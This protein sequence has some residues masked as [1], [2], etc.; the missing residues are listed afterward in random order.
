MRMHEDPQKNISKAERLV[1]KA[2]DRGASIVCLPELF[3]T[4]YFAQYEDDKKAAKLAQRAPG[5]LCDELGG[6]AI[7]ED[8][9][10]VGGSLYEKEGKKLFNTAPVF[11]KDGRMVGKYRKMHI[12]HDFSYYEQNYF[13]PGDLGF[14]VVD[15]SAGR[16]APLICYDQWFPEAARSV[17]LMGADIIFYPTAIGRLRDVIEVE[18]NWQEAWEAAMRGQAICNS[19]PIAA[20][21]RCGVEDDMQFW[22]GSFLMDAFGNLAAHAR[23]GDRVLVPEVHPLHTE[24]VREG[25]KFY[26]N[27][28][29]EQYQTL[30]QRKAKEV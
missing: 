27:R 16:I 4:R 25:W 20:V 17:A 24:W 5:P 9:V 19:I 10:L 30:V 2:A 6:I 15:T 21:N 7:A 8:V 29:P 11:E 26:Q 3:S 18:G 1:Q 23:W 12:P 28:R 13:S 22:G 14:Q